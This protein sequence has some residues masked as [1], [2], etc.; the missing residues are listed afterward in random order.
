[1]LEIRDDEMPETW[2]YHATAGALSLILKKYDN[3]VSKDYTHEDAKLYINYVP[4]E[5]ARVSVIAEGNKIIL[6]RHYLVETFTELP[7]EAEDTSGN[8]LAK[9]LEKKVKDFISS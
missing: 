3:P 4:G 8:T 2:E 5:R 1:M 7:K 9:L 6:G